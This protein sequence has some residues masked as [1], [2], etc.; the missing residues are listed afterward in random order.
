[1][2]RGYS[3]SDAQQRFAI[4]LEPAAYCRSPDQ[5]NRQAAV[6]YCAPIAPEIR[7]AA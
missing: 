7:A 5:S 4:V 2:A 1:M 3:L 6:E